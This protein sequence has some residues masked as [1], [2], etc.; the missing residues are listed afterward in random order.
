[1]AYWAILSGCLWYYCLVA[2]KP[3][4]ETIYNAM[5]VA[6][7][8]NCIL[9]I[10]QK[11][12]V[13]ENF[14]VWWVQTILAGGHNKLPVGLLGNQNLSSALI[15]IC[16]PAFLRRK[17]VYLIPILIVGLVLAKTSGGVVALGAGFM[18]YAWLKG[19]RSAALLVIASVI[20]LY[21][22]YNPSYDSLTNRFDAWKIGFGLW[23][24]SWLTGWGVGHWKVLFKQVNFDGDWWTVAH[25]EP[26]QMTVEMGILFPV[27]LFGYLLGVIK[28][29]KNNTDAILPLMAICIIFVNSLV[30]FP[31]HIATTAIAA[32]TWMAI[33]DY[34]ETVP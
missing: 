30:N 29:F 5:C 2:L 33:F 12:Q 10:C 23:Q 3:E 15:A 8:I 24:D 26:L 27:V 22:L 9:I 11:Y 13:F 32:I 19:Q 14:P 6:V 7:V 25:N 20:G 1:M 16:F 18:L 17:W 21:F 34:E 31:F 4:P 28:R